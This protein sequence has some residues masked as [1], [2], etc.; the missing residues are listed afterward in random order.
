M[1]EQ[2]AIAIVGIL[3]IPITYFAI[4]LVNR[5][6]NMG[7]AY[8]AIAGA[9]QDAVE[10]MNAVMSELRDQVQLL[11]EENKALRDEVKKLH[12]E[13]ENLRRQLA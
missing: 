3:G 9:S 2:L 10:T 12:Q 4:W 1:S 7:E 13:V 5:K 11:K 8:S 6:K